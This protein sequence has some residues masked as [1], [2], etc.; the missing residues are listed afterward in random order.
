MKI[1]RQYV[2]EYDIQAHI[3]VDDEW[4]A[5]FVK[6]YAAEAGEEP[7][8]SEIYDAAL[9]SDLFTEEIDFEEIGDE[10]AVETWRD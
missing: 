8:I 1:V 6:K 4:V 9:E 10:R 5:E 7:S 2:K 3:D